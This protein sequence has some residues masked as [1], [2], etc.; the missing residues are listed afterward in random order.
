[1]NTVQIASVII[2]LLTIIIVATERI[3]KMYVSL[4]GSGAMVLVGAVGAEE[5]L[6]FIHIEILA[7]IVGMMLL[8]RGAERSGIFNFIAKKI[9]K[10]SRSLN[11]FAI[12]L[13]LLTD[14]MKLMILQF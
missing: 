13:M 1:M 11:S 14:F 7:V 12:V 9:T 8:V 10:A 3:P 6:H 5:I 4:L 2:F